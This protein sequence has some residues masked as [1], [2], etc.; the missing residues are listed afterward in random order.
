MD[1]IK[2]P[3]MIRKTDGGFCY[4]TTDMAAIKN[5]IQEEKGDWLI[6]ITDAG[7]VGTFR[8]DNQGF[9]VIIIDKRR[10]HAQ[11]LLEPKNPK[12]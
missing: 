2:V 12:N 1:G 4:G 3:L 7:Q 8:V 6:Y 9:S 5:R 10:D 11:L